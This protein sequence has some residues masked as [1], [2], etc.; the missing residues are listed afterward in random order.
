L[1]SAKNGATGGDGSLRFPPP[2][3][4]RLNQTEHALFSILP[5]GRYLGNFI[6]SFYINNGILFSL[7]AN[8]YCQELLSN[9]NI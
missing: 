9:F 8:I 2:S 5:F 6:V 3:M 1:N 4:N 7:E